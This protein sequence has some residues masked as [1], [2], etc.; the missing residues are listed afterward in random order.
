MTSQNLFPLRMLGF[1]FYW[2][3]LF[4]TCVSPSL[5]LEQESVIGLPFEST[6]LIFRLIF[7]AI[8]LLA[9]KK[10]SNDLSRK[11]LFVISLACGL[12]SSALAITGITQLAIIT[13]IL[14]GATD[15]C[16]FML[17]MCFFGNNRIGEVAIYLASSY[18]L[19]AA[20]S[21]LISAL[22]PPIALA[23]AFLL[24]V[25]S[26]V[27]YALSYKHCK[28]DESEEIH[29][30]I[31]K[32]PYPFK[33]FPFIG[34]I[35]WALCLYALVF[36]MTTST[37]VSNGLDS[38]LVGPF[39]ETPC[40]IIVGLSLTLAFRCLKD[41][42]PIY[43]VYKFVPLFLSLGLASLLFEDA[44]STTIACF[45]VMAAYLA[46]EI[47]ALNDLC[48]EV[49]LRGLSAIKI[50]GRARAMITLGM[51]AGWLLGSLSQLL[52]E[53]ISPLLFTAAICMP[54]VII[55][56]TLVF[57]EKEI[58][59]VRAATDERKNIEGADEIPSSSVLH[60]ADSL[61]DRI[62]E[63]FGAEWSLSNREMEVLPL[64]LSGK[65]ATY[66]SEKLFIARGTTKTH[67]YNIYR[68]MGIHSKME[69][70][71]MFEEYRAKTLSNSESKDAESRK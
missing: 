42:Q 33:L 69:M 56:S 70:F 52:S 36:G 8:I 53:A 10:L 35:C 13:V 17:W 40:C 11:I 4:L 50:F 39:V 55:A 24:P 49:K 45:L 27:T 62:I 63:S 68:K 41:I 51:L 25:L 58:F 67:I 30:H 66:I 61:Q 29:E 46:F 14:L 34:R 64:L 28:I 26:C 1:G 20:V 54:L 38:F 60:E 16:M 18:A 9:S 19:G 65:T 6:E 12:L 47:L 5:I 32:E 15:A 37:I 3:W 7:I 44:L 2:A 23:C 71:D 59:A 43:R 22:N 48:N 21:L 31:S 57:T